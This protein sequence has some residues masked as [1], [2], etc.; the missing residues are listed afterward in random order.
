[1]PSR[2]ISRSTRARSGWRRSKS[3]Q[4]RLDNCISSISRR[5]PSS[6][7]ICA[8]SCAACSTSGRIAGMSF[9]GDSGGGTATATG[10]RA[11]SVAGAVSAT[12]G[13]DAA[14]ASTGT[15]A[16]GAPCRAASRTSDSS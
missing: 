16:N 14:S 10:G 3:F 7:R 8:A 2:V 13:L 4:A 15:A 12:R 6:L 1:M 9:A 11:S 5:L